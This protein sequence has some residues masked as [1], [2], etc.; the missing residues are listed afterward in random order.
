MRAILLTLAFL[1]VA[2]LAL[3]PSLA[4]AQAAMP[5]AWPQTVGTTAA[6]VLPADDLR[7]TVYFRNVDATA[8]IAVCPAVSR[9]DGTN[10]TCA[11]HGAG[12]VTLT[13]GDSIRIS[14]L[15]VNGEIP[16]AWNAIASAPGATLTALEF[17]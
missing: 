9:K 12:S 10:I 3:A 15:G 17:E 13:P 7:K 16:T 8:T 11:V 5:Y 14:G 6:Q 4:N 2:L 1:A